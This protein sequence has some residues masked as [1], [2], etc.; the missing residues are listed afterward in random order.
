[1]NEEWKDKEIRQNGAHSDKRSLNLITGKYFENEIFRWDQVHVQ[2]K[3]A[4]FI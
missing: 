1:M 2:W 4:P 3:V